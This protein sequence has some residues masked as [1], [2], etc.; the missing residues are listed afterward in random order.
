[1]TSARALVVCVALV[2]AGAEGPAAQAPATAR[3]A[4]VSPGAV[5]ARAWI[6]KDRILNDSPVRLWVV[7]ENGLSTEI[8]G[9]EFDDFDTPAFKPATCWVNHTPSCKDGKGEALPELP[10]IAPHSALAVS[11]TMTRDPDAIDAAKVVLTAAF[12]W[13]LPG[14]EPKRPK[15]FVGPLQP[16]TQHGVLSSGA[17]ELLSTRLYKAEWVTSLENAIKDL[18]MPVL[19]GIGGVLLYRYQQS[20]T[21]RQ[22]IWT[23]MLSKVTSDTE[24]HYLPISSA[25]AE[26]VK[27]A[28]EAKKAGSTAE[29]HLFPLLLFNANVRHFKQKKGGWYFKARRAEDVVGFAWVAYKRSERRA[30]PSEAIDDAVGRIKPNAIYGNCKTTVASIFATPVV[31][32]PPATATPVVSGAPATIGQTLNHWMTA[33]N[34]ESEVARLLTILKDVIDVEM[35]R[36]FYMWYDTRPASH[37]RQFAKHIAALKTLENDMRAGSRTDAADDVKKLRAALQAYGGNF[38]QR[39]RPRRA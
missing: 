30:L 37:S 5:S 29:R 36:P 21:E 11:A 26:L 28:A 16:I 33:G 31:S 17:I 35:D 19:L 8:D 23:A 14:T 27:A 10:A 18:L 3:Q 20:R 22:A 13:R 2:S 12:H 7:I 32:G 9:V 25:A 34:F 4:I 1:M 6:D 39:Y 38:W 15:G 24:R